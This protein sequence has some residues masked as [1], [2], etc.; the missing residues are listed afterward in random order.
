MV[1][2]PLES[3]GE[4]KLSHFGSADPPKQRVLIDIDG[5]RASFALTLPGRSGA[6]GL[7]KEYRTSDFP[8]ATDC[9]MR[10][11]QDAGITLEGMDCAVAVSGAL[12]GDAVRIARCPWIISV[13]GLRYL[14][15][16]PVHFLND[17]AAMLWAATHVGTASHRPLGPYPLPDF[18]KGG[19]WLGINYQTGLGAALLVGQSGSVLQHVETEAGHV[20]FAPVGNTE[21]ILHRN[22]ERSKSPVSW[23]RALFATPDDPAWRD[24][25]LAGDPRLL[26]ACRA[27]MLGSFVGDMVLATGAW[28]GI[29]LFGGA[30]SLVQASGNLALFDKR[31]ESR[32]NF[33]LQ[34][35]KV[36]RWAVNLPHINLVG[37]SRFLEHRCEA[38]PNMA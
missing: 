21:Q 4:K 36:P 2:I 32:A 33:Q 9:V 34:L 27:E 8:T 23:E 25:P 15:K 38:I 11:A 26:A 30:V 13:T 5:V 3:G 37:A 14:F 20:A 16:T 35:R 22:L 31:L 17:S 29:L 24:T 6:L 12:S 28:D 18:T 19:K 1:A 7:V 10:F